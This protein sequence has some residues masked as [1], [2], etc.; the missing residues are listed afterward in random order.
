VIPEYETTP[1][2]VVEIIQS[3]YERGKSHAII[4]VAEGAQH[5]AAELAAYC[6]ENHDDLGFKL[7][8]TTLGHVQRGGDPSA[9]DRILASRLG[10]AA[11]KRL[12]EGGHGVLTGWI[13]GS[14]AFTQLEEVV[15]NKKPLSEELIELAR[16][17]D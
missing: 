4:V 2:Q 5:N 11:A 7:R 9:Y 12:L 14:V 8:S 15:A 1:Q 17:L 13:G 3:A 16:V 6:E 10:A